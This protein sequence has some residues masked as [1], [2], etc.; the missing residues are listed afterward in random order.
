MAAGLLFTGGAAQAAIADYAGS[1]A[2]NLSSMETPAGGGQ[3]VETFYGRLEVK[4]APTGVTTGKLSTRA[5]KSYPLKTTLTE[6][7]GEAMQRN[8]G[9][10][11]LKGTNATFLINFRLTVKADGSVLVSGENFNPGDANALFFATGSW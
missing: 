10:A 6:G 7:A 9:L 2:V 11:P 1:Y 4:V 5:G 3:A 8:V